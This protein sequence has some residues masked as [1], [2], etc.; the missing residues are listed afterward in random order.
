MSFRHGQS[1][2]H[3]HAAHST[4][5]RGEGALHLSFSLL[6]PNE[7]VPGGGGGGVDEL[8]MEVMRRVPIYLDPH[9]VSAEVVLEQLK[10]MGEQPVKESHSGSGGA[11]HSHSHTAQGAVTVAAGAGSKRRKMGEP[12][13]STL[14][15]VYFG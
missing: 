3:R 6:N 10:R 14:Y 8:N 4:R 11:L 13:V 1:G 5:W 15:A 7:A 2:Q 9:H 12:G